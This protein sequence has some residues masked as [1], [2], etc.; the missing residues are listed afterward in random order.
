MKIQQVKGKGGKL[1]GGEVR[2]S[3]EWGG[4]RVVL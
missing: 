1:P 2:V 3:R 4:V